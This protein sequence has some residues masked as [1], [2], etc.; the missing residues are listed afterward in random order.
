MN[1]DTLQ[2]MGVV[3]IVVVA[4]AYVLRRVWRKQRGE[5][6]ACGQ[7]ASCAAQRKAGT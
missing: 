2:G 6:P 4:V 3:A 1:N 5:A 7:C